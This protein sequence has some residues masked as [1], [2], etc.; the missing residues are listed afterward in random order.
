MTKRM[1]LRRRML[2]QSLRMPPAKMTGSP[3]TVR[4]QR[5]VEARS[6]DPNDTE[7]FEQM[8]LKLEKQDVD[9]GEQ[10]VTGR[11]EHREDS[12]CSI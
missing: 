9:R 11:D 1:H 8:R 6:F 7:F 4:H 12:L 10:A 2:N 3:K 5:P